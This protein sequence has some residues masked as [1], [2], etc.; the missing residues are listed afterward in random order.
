MR[1]AILSILLLAVLGASA[2]S[3]EPA[4]AREPL[5]A[6][7]LLAPARV[8]GHGRFDAARP[9]YQAKRAAE[10]AAAAE[11]RTRCSCAQQR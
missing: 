9:S 7:V 5:W 8:L 10:K 2:P 3:S 11:A 6:T 4:A 1:S